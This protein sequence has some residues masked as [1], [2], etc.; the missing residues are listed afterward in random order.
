[1]A[2]PT[3]LSTRPDL[4]ENILLVPNLSCA[5]SIVSSGNGSS[6]PKTVIVD[7]RLG[8]TVILP[9]KRGTDRKKIKVLERHQ[10]VDIVVQLIEPF[11]VCE[12]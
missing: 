3:I 2:T 8:K 6:Q 12:L 4:K 1:M 7:S 11:K 9:R 5:A 10:A